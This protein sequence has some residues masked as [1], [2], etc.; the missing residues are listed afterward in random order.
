MTSSTN[1][2]YI[3]LNSSHFFCRDKKYANTEHIKTLK[4]KRSKATFRRHIFCKI[5]NPVLEKLKKLAY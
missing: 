5:T 2:S 3:T 1:G 4:I